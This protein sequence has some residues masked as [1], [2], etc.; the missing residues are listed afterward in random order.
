[1]NYVIEAA[2]LYERNQAVLPVIKMVTYPSTSPQ[3]LARSVRKSS[4]SRRRRCSSA[5]TSQSHSNSTDTSNLKKDY[6]G[7]TEGE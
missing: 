3:N 6:N 1:M 7:L 2:F 4:P 5:P